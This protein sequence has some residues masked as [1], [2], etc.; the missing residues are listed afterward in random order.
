MKHTF[1]FL[2]TFCMFS[3]SG[4][5]TQ[6]H[7]IELPFKYSDENYLM[8]LGEEQGLILFRESKERGNKKENWEILVLDIN[9]EEKLSFGIEVDFKYSI[10]GY[11][12]SEGYFYLLFT[13]D[14]TSKS[15]FLLVKASI[16]N[17]EVINYHIANELIID[18]SHLL[19]NNELLVLGGY[20]NF[21]PIFMVFDYLNDKI[22]VV[23]GF[24]NS[25]SEILDFNYD[26]AHNAYNV[27]MV[28]K[29]ALNHNEIALKSFDKNG[30][31]LIDE[32][33]EFNNNWRALNGRIIIGN[34]N[35]IIVS[36]SYATNNSYY[37]QGYY[38][39]SLTSGKNLSMKYIGF[40]KIDH[41]FDYMSPKRV[42][43][44]KSKIKKSQGNNKTYEFKTHVFVHE[45]R[46]N[47]NEF[48]VV[49]ELYSP[50][51]KQSSSSAA[52]GYSDPSD[53]GYRDETR[54]KYVNRSSK[55]TNTDG[56][57]H[58]SY[59]ES[60]VLGLDENGKLL[61]NQSIPLSE[62]ETLALE[63]VSQVYKTKEKGVLLYRNEDNLIYKSFDSR[64]GVLL[65]S[66]VVID[67]FKEFDEISRHTE[68]QGSIQHWYGNNF[69]VWGYQKISNNKY[70]Q[71]DKK[72]N[73]F[74][75][76]K[77]LIE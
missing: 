15:D 61:W 33:Y 66:S 73:I 52:M 10:M 21:R 54:Q 39:G 49:S 36:G 56:A 48:L 74:F 23:P 6:T 67:T 69:I 58:I 45:L 47:E 68:K 55:L 22:E 76:N 72:R 3:A 19:I 75:I 14:N 53:R 25:K 59:Y 17:G 26:K 35:R 65:D 16:E 63:Q 12:Y 64:E 1:T 40:T 34:N 18:V 20:V 37:S 42:A 24:F 9:L 4:Q 43:R 2:L 71:A 7:R 77:L 57:S 27:L 60:V 51:F 41:F 32:R 29:N 8:E 11:D 62:I 38:F 30:E 28:Q 5:I 70:V 13:N 46:E 50:E 31:I 44:I